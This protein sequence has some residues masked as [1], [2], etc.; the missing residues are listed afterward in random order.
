MRYALV[1]IALAGLACGKQTFLAAAFVQTPSLPNP[2]DPNK[3]FPQYQVMTAYF[4]TIDTTDPT[5]ID[6]SKIADIKDAAA[7]VAFHHRKQTPQDLPEGDRYICMPASPACAAPT[8]GWT[9]ADTGHGSAYV[10]NSSSESQL[11]FEV[12]T[13]YTLVLNTAGPDGEAFGAR[14]TPG[15]APD[16]QEFSDAATCTITL[17]APASPVTVKRCVQASLGRVTQALS[18]ITRTEP[19]VNGSRLPAFLVVANMGDPS[20]GNLNTANLQACLS[21]SPQEGCFKTIPSDAPA[22]LKYVLSDIPYRWTT[23]NVDEQWFKTPG[24]YVVALLSVNA[25][26]VSGNAFLGSTALAASGTAG[27]VIV[28]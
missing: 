13:P 8:S 1:A 16:M 26:K 25:G 22:L 24:Y 17:P 23:Y 11:T 3:P 5:K 14:L 27:V 20:K 12:N 19:L 2:A 7:S 28:Q 18:K 10:L 4:G 21:P 6:P 9:R 15:P